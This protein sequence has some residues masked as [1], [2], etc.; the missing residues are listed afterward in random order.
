MKKTEDEHKQARA[1]KRKQV[2]NQQKQAQKEEDKFDTH[3]FGEREKE[4]QRNRYQGATTSQNTE[5]P[6]R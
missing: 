3:V 4:R 2:L 6:Y 1:W 5:Q